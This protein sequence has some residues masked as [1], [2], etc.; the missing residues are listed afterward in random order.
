[1]WKEPHKPWSKLQGQVQSSSMLLASQV[2]Q[3]RRRLSVG[4]VEN[5]ETVEET[6]SRQHSLDI[7]IDMHT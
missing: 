7:D 6:A 2:L 5:E 1:M 3:Q 4:I